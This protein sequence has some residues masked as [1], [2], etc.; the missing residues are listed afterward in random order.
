M[1]SAKGWLL[2]GVV[3]LVA[4]GGGYW[5]WTRG[6]DSVVVGGE[7]DVPALESETWEADLSVEQ[8]KSDT[9]GGETIFSS[10]K[11]STSWVEPSDVEVDHYEIVATDSVMGWTTETSVEN[12]NSV[13]LWGLKSET[14]YTLELTAC[15]DEE[16][17]EQLVAD[18]SAKAS[19]S[20]EYWQ[21]QGTGHGYD[22]ATQVVTTGKGSTLSYVLPYGDW[23]PKN[24]QGKVKYYFS[25]NSRDLGLGIG[26]LISINETGKDDI[27]SLSAFETTGIFYE[28]NCQES[29]QGNN[30]NSGMEPCSN[31]ELM[32]L[33]FQMVPLENGE[34]RVFFEA[35]SKESENTMTTTRIYSMDSQDGYEG[36][37]FNP[38]PNKEFCSSTDMVEGG[39]CKPTFLIGLSSDGEDS[40]LTQ[41]RQQ[42]VGYPK[43]DSW[44]WDESEGTFMVITGQDSCDQTRDG[45]FYGVW[46]GEEWKI[47]TEEDCAIPLVLDAHGPVIVHL[48]EANYK[49]YYE[50]YEYTDRT[51]MQN[52]SYDVKPTRVLYASGAESGE[53]SIVDLA[54]WEDEQDAREIY[55][56]WPDGT[57]LDE[58]EEA[59]LGDH[60][61]WSPNEDLETQIMYMNL[62]GFDNQDWKQPPVGLGMA[63]LV[64]P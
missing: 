18:A 26:M 52:V 55:F 17:E 8:L 61:I 30:N 49:L 45:L 5:Q 42:K 46:D 35:G 15:L 21:L 58:Q 2:G 23:A 28:R 62:G 13:E 11:L 3:L 32:M 53:E 40:P 57:L 6:E 9:I 19:T 60:V 63:V 50:N 27:E 31:G 47:E 20:A 4:L 54:D 37:D 1:N 59:G 7:T 12:T 29:G 44:L 41:A 16:C 38:D 34:I 10:G 43:Q 25:A 64:N 39:D 14:E 48:G 22:D 56:L 36:E 24:L 33:A 51:N